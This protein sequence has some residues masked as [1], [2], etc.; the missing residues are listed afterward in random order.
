M[1]SCH[2]NDSGMLI[3]DVI[4]NDIHRVA[5]VIFSALVLPS[6]QT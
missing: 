2:S 1:D 5:S 4:V 6:L 3:D